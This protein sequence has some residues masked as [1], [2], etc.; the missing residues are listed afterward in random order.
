MIDKRETEELIERYCKGQ[1]LPDEIKIF[2]QWLESDSSLA[3]AVE[4]HQTILAVF[5][6]STKREQLRS[7]L[8]V[9][10]DEMETEQFAFKAPLKKVAEE[11]EPSRIRQFYRQY[12]IIS[13]AAMVTIVAVS[14]TL[15]TSALTGLFSN[16][17]Q[18]NYQALSR[19]VER[20]I[21]ARRKPGPAPE[22]AG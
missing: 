7:T 8:N 10:H 2:E 12:R 11:K 18:G 6:L 15:I 4:Q 20:L 5:N 3:E 22:P 13:I 14:G 21:E 17:Q 19:E 9:I 16:K 1:L